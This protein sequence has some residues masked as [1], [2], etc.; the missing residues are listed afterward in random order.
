MKGLT[1]EQLEFLKEHEIPL[2]R[3]FDASGY[4]SKEYREIMKLSGK[5]FA[6]NVTPCQAYGH[7]LRTRAGHCI[8][9]DTA[10][11]GFMKRNDLGGVVYIAGTLKGEIIKIGFSQSLEGREESLNRNEYAGFNDW[12]TIYAIESPIAGQI[13]IKIKCLMSPYNREFDYHHDG[14]Q[15]GSEETYTCSYSKAKNT[16]TALCKEQNF[17]IKVLKDLNTNQFEFRNLKRIK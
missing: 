15:Q 11:I 17:N 14:H 12:K 7:T 3:V 6:F 2:D 13:E 8:Q 4:T 16:L 10:R 5:S 9:C 1:K